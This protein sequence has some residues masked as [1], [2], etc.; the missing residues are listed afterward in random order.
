MDRHRHLNRPAPTLHSPHDNDGHEWKLFLTPR[1]IEKLAV[2]VLTSWV[3]AAITLV[4]NGRFNPIRFL[5]CVGF[6]TVLLVL[7]S[8]LCVLIAMAL[9]KPLSW[10]K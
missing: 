5:V 7:T 9:Q 3:F 8:G 10:F 1:E 2:V 4:C 6:I